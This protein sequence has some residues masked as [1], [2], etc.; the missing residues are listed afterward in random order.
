MKVQIKQKARGPRKSLDF[1][2]YIYIIVEQLSLSFESSQTVES[3]TLLEGN[4][5][6]GAF[7]LLPAGTPVDAGT[8]RREKNLFVPH[9]RKMKTSWGGME[10]SFTLVSS[11]QR[12]NS[13]CECTLGKKMRKVAN[14]ADL[15]QIIHPV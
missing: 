14:V 10:T 2:K 13:E 8:C 1:L 7:L 15:V 12:E 3:M 5:G 6:G 9:F 11:T 4:S